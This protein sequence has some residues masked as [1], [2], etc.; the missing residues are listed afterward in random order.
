MATAEQRAASAAATIGQ[1]I[2]SV[3]GGIFPT[4]CTVTPIAPL[5]GAA[6]VEPARSAN[7]AVVAAGAD[8]SSWIDDAGAA[9][10]RILSAADAPTENL[11]ETA[12]WTAIGIIAIVSVVLL[13]LVLF[14][15]F[16]LRGFR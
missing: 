8:A 9:G 6:S 1:G 14:A 4:I 5:L 15:V 11:A 3:F 16:W 7:A 2:C 10:E 12:R 13:L